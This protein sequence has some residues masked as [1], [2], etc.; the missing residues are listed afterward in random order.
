MLGQPPDMLLPSRARKKHRDHIEK[1]AR[2][3]T[4]RRLKNS[5]AEIAGLNKAGT[6]FPA[7]AS[8]SKFDV[9]GERLFTVFPRDLTEQKVAEEHIDEIAD[10]LYSCHNRQKYIN[11]LKSY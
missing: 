6:E 11:I 9:G 4:P 1:F 2:S 10:H 8:I 3:P 5:R 7:D